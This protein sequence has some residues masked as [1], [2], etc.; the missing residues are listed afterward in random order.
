MN[1]TANSCNLVGRR[2][3]HRSSPRLRFDG[4]AHYYFSEG[5]GRAICRDISSN[6]VF[7]RSSRRLDLNTPVVVVFELIPETP[8]LSIKG[9]IARLA[10][11]D[12]EQGM[13]VEFHAEQSDEAVASIS[14]FV[15]ANGGALEFTGFADAFHTGIEGEPSFAS[16]D[17]SL[18]SNPDAS[19]DAATTACDSI[20]SPSIH[21]T[22]A[23]ADRG[24]IE[25]LC[26]DKKA[27]ILKALEHERDAVARHAEQLKIR[28]AK[29]D[30]VEREL[31]QRATKLQSLEEEARRAIELRTR[32]QEARLH[33]LN[34][35][36]ARL[37][38][39]AAKL[40][41]LNQERRT[42]R[43]RRKQQEARQAELDALERQLKLKAEELAALQDTLDQQQVAMNQQ[44]D[45]IAVGL[46]PVGS[47]LA[48]EHERIQPQGMHAARQRLIDLELRLEE[49]YK[50]RMAQLEARAAAFVDLEQDLHEERKRLSLLA[51]K[52]DERQH[53]VQREESM[54]PNGLP[55]ARLT[56]NRTT[57]RLPNSTRPHLGFRS[58]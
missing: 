25:D 34:E 18:D 23:E 53:T 24:I 31:E 36:E 51:S 5:D 43:R 20:D 47:V 57:E 22:A 6:G 54:R 42:L 37:S 21:T 16:P 44:Q 29:L 11:P 26:V 4:Q 52:L 10:G 30:D 32:E 12:E 41:D 56:D 55:A 9:R 8:P 2:R 49:A 27:A 28:L 58:A 35:L 3:N 7:L 1:H 45:A 17:A 15:I 50:D 13:G 19:P 46:V 40:Q 38:N 33:E 39:K 14:S 48:H